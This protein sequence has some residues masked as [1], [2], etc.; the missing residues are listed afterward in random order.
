MSEDRAL[1]E[2]LGVVN[3]ELVA[4]VAT[5]R[6]L[7]LSL[8]QQKDTQQQLNQVSGRG[9]W[10]WRILEVSV[11]RVPSGADCGYEAAAYRITAKR[12]TAE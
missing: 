12:D 9:M 6:E 11:C 8:E 5:L 3:R 2:Q 1:A 4:A 10:A 7:Q